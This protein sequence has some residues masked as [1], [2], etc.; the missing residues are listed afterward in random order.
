MILH[1][2][3]ESDSVKEF[4]ALVDRDYTLDCQ[5]RNVLQNE[6][7][8]K[9]PE[10]GRKKRWKRLVGSD[11]MWQKKA[12]LQRVEFLAAVCGMPLR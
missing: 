9:L 3:V 8:H 7:G 5:M 6:F 11:L 10:C 2:H 1:G 4:F 12:S